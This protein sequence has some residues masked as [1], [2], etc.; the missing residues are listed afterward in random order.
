MDDSNFSLHAK[1]FDIAAREA[2]ASMECAAKYYVRESHHRL[3]DEI[4]NISVSC[5]GTWMKRGFT[6]IHGVVAVIAQETGQV[7]DYAV[8]TKNCHMCNAIRIQVN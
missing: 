6:S 3:A 1:A 5:D 7:T 4:V 2:S 8:L